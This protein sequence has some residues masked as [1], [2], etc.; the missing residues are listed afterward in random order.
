[1]GWALDALDL[2]EVAPPE[3]DEATSQ[4]F[5]EAR[6]QAVGLTS[7]LARLG[8]GL[9]AHGVPAVALKGSALLV[10]N[11]ARALGVRWLSDIDLLVPEAPADGAAWVAQSLGYARGGRANDQLQAPQRPYHETFVGP[12]GHLL[13]EVHR[14]LG[15]PRWGPAA[16][17]AGWFDCAS[18]S[19]IG[20]ILAPAPCDLFWHQLLHDARNHAWSSGSLRAAFELA[21]TARSPGFSLHDVLLHLDGDRHPEPLL[22]AVADAAHLSPILAAEIEPSLEPRYLRLAR[23]R[24]T[25]GRRKWETHRI[26]EAI[27]WGATL[28]RMRRF[29]GWRGVMERALTVIPDAA[30]RTGIGALWR[31]GFLNARH[32]GFVTLLAAAHLFTIPVPPTPR[33][34]LPSS[35]PRDTA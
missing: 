32:A 27:A 20:G 4:A 22:E 21:V 16:D 15:P 5:A 17:G 35:T 14:R 19:T 1:M 3:V 10:S 26:S 34:A 7:D 28:D 33:R 6:A 29:G 9:Q 13:L 11:V 2:R 18:P 12:E 30:P 25:I 8:A 31:R 23:W 24:D